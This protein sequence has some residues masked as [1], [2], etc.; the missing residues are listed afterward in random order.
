MHLEISK[1]WSLGLIHLYSGSNASFDY[2]E[3]E[4]TKLGSALKVDDLVRLQLDEDGNSSS[5][6]STWRV[7][8]LRVHEPLKHEDLKL[9]DT[10]YYFDRQLVREFDRL[11]SVRLVGVMKSD[12]NNPRY[13]FEDKEHNIRREVDAKG[14]PKIYPGRDYQ[15][16][17]VV[18]ES[19][20]NENRKHEVDFGSIEN[21]TFIVDVGQTNIVFATGKPATYGDHFKFTQEVSRFIQSHFNVH[22]IREIARFSLFFYLLSRSLMGYVAFKA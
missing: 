21:E 14:F 19:V 17:K 22:Q 1:L 18:F 3:N 8:E 15:T 11:K 5:D 12:E 13:T 10:Y 7:T 16:A 9:D 2:K 6:Y 20:D 4:I